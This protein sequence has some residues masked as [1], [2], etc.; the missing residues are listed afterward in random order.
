MQLFHFRL[1][2]CYSSCKVPR[3]LNS[4]VLSICRLDAAVAPRVWGAAI[5]TV[6]NYV[7]SFAAAVGRCLGGMRFRGSI[8]SAI[9]DSD[10]HIDEAVSFI[11][12]L[13]YVSSFL[14]AAQIQFESRLTYGSPQDEEEMH[15]LS[16]NGDNDDHCIERTSFT[17]SSTCNASAADDT[18]TPSPRQLTGLVFL[19]SRCSNRSCCISYGFN[20]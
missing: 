3:I 13:I 8:Y 5:R 11:T 2:C 4:F 19:V 1:Y 16:H 10:A 14:V 20:R 15:P 17:S 7:A 9:R 6:F 18:R 12:S